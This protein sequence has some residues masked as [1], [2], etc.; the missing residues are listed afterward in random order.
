[1]GPH[2]RNGILRG[3]RSRRET[4][5]SNEACETRRTGPRPPET[6]T[7]SV[8]PSVQRAVTF[9]PARPAG[10]LTPT[11]AHQNFVGPPFS[12]SALLNS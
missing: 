7:P 5:G 2:S 1:M 12:L 8:R 11:F 4:S 3:G 9:T 6:W 10:D